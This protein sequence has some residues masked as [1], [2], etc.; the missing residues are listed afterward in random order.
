M[1]LEY[2]SSDCSQDPTNY[3]KFTVNNAQIDI[4]MDVL[5]NNVFVFPLPCLSIKIFPRSQILR[6]DFSPCPPL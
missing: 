2:S 5:G 3:I 1:S 4:N 6:G